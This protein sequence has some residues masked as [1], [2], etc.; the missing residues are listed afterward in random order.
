MRTFTQLFFIRFLWLV[1]LFLGIGEVWG[2]YRIETVAGV[3]IESITA[4]KAGF[5]N[6]HGITID[7]IGNL[8]IAD[9]ENHRVRKLDIATNIVST[10]AGKMGIRGFSGDGESAINALLNYPS[11]VVVDGIGN[12]YISDSGNQRIRK[13]E[14]SSGNIITIAGTGKAGFS[15]DYRKA[16][17]AKLNYPSGIAID[18][19]NNIYVADR[20]NHRIRKILSSTNEIYTI[21][22]LGTP[23]FSGDGGMAIACKMQFPS[24]VIVD[25][26]GALYI[27]DRNNHRVRKINPNSQIITTIVGNGFYGFAGDKEAAYLAKISYVENISIDQKGNIY[28]ADQGNLRIR[29]V[30]VN[31][32]IIE[33]I[34]GTGNYSFTGNS[35]LAIDVDLVNPTG[36]TTDKQGNIYITDGQRFIKKITVSDGLITTIAGSGIR[37]DDNI[38]FSGDYQKATSA[39]LSHPTGITTDQAG[40]LYIADTDNH[41]IRK[42]DVLSGIITTIAGT[43][44]NNYWGDG[45]K[46]IDANLSYP[47][48]LAIDKQGNIYIADAG[49]NQIRKINKSNNIITTIAGTGQ[50]GYSGDQGLAS[51][52]MLRYPTDIALDSSNNIYFT[53]KD[54]H[55][56]RKIDFSTKQITTIAGNGTSGYS[57]DNAQAIYSQLNKPTGVSLDSDGNIYIADTENH[58]IRRISIKTGIITTI[59]GNGIHGV[60]SHGQLAIDS[61]LSSPQKICLDA[62]GDIYIAERNNYFIKKIN[63]STGI[64]HSISTYFSFNWARDITLDHTGAIYIADSENNRIRKLSS[65]TQMRVKKGQYTFLSGDTLNFGAVWLGKTEPFEITLENLGGTVLNIQD[66][67]ASNNFTLK[68]Q[69]PSLVPAKGKVLLQ[70]SVKGEKLGLTKGSII[71]KSN[72]LDHPIYLINIKGVVT[73]EGQKLAQSLDFQ[74]LPTE[75]QNGDKIRLMASSSAGLNV[76]FT[77]SNPVVAITLDNELKIIRKGTSIITASQPGNKY[78]KSAPEL[79][80]TLTIKKNKQVINFNLG[81]D[82]LKSLNAASFNINALA[83]S[84]LPITFTSSNT[85]VAIISGNLVIIKGAGITT[86]TANQRGNNEF[87]AA[88]SVSQVLQVIITKVYNLSAEIQGRHAIKLIWQINLSQA[89]ETRLERSEGSPNNFAEVITDNTTSYLDTSLSIKPGVTYYYRA[90][91]KGDGG[92]EAL[93]SDTVGVKIPKNEVVTGTTSSDFAKKLQIFPNP[94]KSGLFQVKWPSPLLPQN[95]TLVLR[96]AQGRTLKRFAS[97]PP[98][99]NLQKFPSGVYYLSITM[100]NEEVVKKLIKE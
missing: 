50:R 31:S 25:T 97:P 10:I 73:E 21:A 56:V 49:N 5:N 36:I 86:I 29:R 6:P 55:C 17:L 48:G 81:A 63:H 77:S 96:D 14:A 45:G 88:P 76:T 28:I 65:P 72:D 100:P 83:S 7:D 42:V 27:A 43:G 41:R 51:L 40:N 20:C 46:A 92:I 2:Q 69:Y 13:I 53:D 34:A 12:I 39:Q 60:S 37:N 3:D 79:S 44:E 82:S 75:L 35:D 62:F 98:Q 24:D 68:T 9:T 90:I 4:L 22:G 59:A 61:Q 19:S 15:G 87:E 71:I 16:T 94:N 84:Y 54:N 11:D 91:A 26:L 85:N 93:P 18:K 64:I 78:Y 66:I 1:W 99:I 8:Y 67:Q 70:F 95:I 38:G 32:K 47:S 52:A 33:T 57:G 89:R 58:C 30:N 74:L 23:G 80:Q